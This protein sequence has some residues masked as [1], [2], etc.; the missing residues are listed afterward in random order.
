MADKETKGKKN[1]NNTGNH[2]QKER[3][4]GLTLDLVALLAF[5]ILAVSFFVS[6]QMPFLEY[7]V[8]VLIIGS[9]FLGKAII[10]R[11]EDILNT[12]NLTNTGKLKNYIPLAINLILIALLLF[13]PVR[14]VNNYFVIP[15]TF[16]ASISCNIENGRLKCNAFENAT[17]FSMFLGGLT[18]EQFEKIR[19]GIDIN[20]D[21][22]LNNLTDAFSPK[23]NWQRMCKGEWFSGIWFIFDFAFLSISLLLISITA[24][25]LIKLIREW[26][27][28][29]KVRN[30]NTELSKR[31]KI[32]AIIFSLIFS[33]VFIYFL[34]NMY[35][36]GYLTIIIPI[37]EYIFFYE[38]FS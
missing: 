2:S 19:N 38:H 28:R 35:L 22:S 10:F 31:E 1:D 8:D 27:I 37:V 17:S 32:C 12:E 9:Y 23:S 7:A 26:N 18:S 6:N 20:K 25:E 14:F 24:I 15:N 33:T 29:E 13:I 11:I 34:T 36:Q 5:T 3:L 21:D 30:K 4:N 16:S